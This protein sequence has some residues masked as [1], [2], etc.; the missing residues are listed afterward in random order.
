[1]ASMSGVGSSKKRMVTFSDQIPKKSCNEAK[2]CALCKK[3]GV[4]KN[5][6]NMGDCH[7]Y[8]KD[9]TPKKAFAGKNMQHNPRTH[10]Q[11]TNY[12]QLSAKIVKL[13]TSNQNLKHANKN[14]KHNYNSN[15][16]NSNSS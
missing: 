1:M 13:E 4:M 5:T 10:K 9:G 14:C 7:K 15:S 16:N 12:P 11:N 3:Y 2:H 6:Y 8:E